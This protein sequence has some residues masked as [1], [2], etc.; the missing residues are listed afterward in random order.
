MKVIRRRY[1]PIVDLS[2]FT[3]IMK[4][5][6]SVHNQDTKAIGTSENKKKKIQDAIPNTFSTK[7]ATSQPRQGQ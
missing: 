1:N 2:K 7:E 6:Y 4:R 5:E 3:S